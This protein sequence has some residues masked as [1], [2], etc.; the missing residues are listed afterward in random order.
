MS[1]LNEMQLL[2]DEGVALGGMTLASRTPATTFLVLIAAAT[3][4]SI[5]VLVVRH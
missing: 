3:I 5:V 2:Q 4:A 1:F